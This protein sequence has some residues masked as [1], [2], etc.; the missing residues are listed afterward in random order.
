MNRTYAA[1]TLA[2]NKKSRRLIISKIISMMEDA[3]DFEFPISNE[4]KKRNY[5]EG[6]EESYWKSL[7]QTSLTRLESQIYVAMANAAFLV[8]ENEIVNEKKKSN[9]K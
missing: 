6:E 4:H 3:H 8:R 1:Y 7:S 5:M 9:F 2:K